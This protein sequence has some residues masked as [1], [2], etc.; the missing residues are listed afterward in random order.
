MKHLWVILLFVS[1]SLSAKDTIVLWQRNYERAAFL[2]FV[3]LAAEKTETDYGPY[4]VT[5]SIE[6]EQGRAFAELPQGEVLNLAIAG[7]DALREQENLPIF[8]PLHRGILGFKICLVPPGAKGYAD[9]T[10]V[11][12]FN[13]QNQLVGSGS[14]WPDRYIYE[15]NGLKT[16]HTPNYIQLFEMLARSRFDC[17]LRSLNE[18][19]GEMEAYGNLGITADEHIAF[20]YPY[21]DIMFV[22]P[23]APELKKRLEVG[24]QRALADGSFYRLFDEHLMGVMHKYNFYQRR[25]LYLK[26]NQASDAAREA[27]NKY[28]IVSIIE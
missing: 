1:P 21:A 6:M 23:S 17:F 10:S 14:H 7:T 4:E 8:I 26:N 25:L 13:K 9:I 18:V 20:V 3:V 19:D 22:S 5:P 12:Q 27:I 24:L 28:G 16:V 11:E 2:D 15:A